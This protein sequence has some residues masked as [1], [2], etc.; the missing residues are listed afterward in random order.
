MKLFYFMF[1]DNIFITVA[2]K[3]KYPPHPPFILLQFLGQDWLPPDPP[4]ILE[5]ASTGVDF[6]GT[7]T[8]STLIRNASDNASIRRLV[9]NSLNNP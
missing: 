9:G 7:K 2:Y 3:L 8:G 5:G 4:K 6:E 1:G